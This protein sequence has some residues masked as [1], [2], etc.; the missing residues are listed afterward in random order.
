MIKLKKILQNILSESSWDVQEQFYRY[1]DHIAAAIG[2]QI[3]KKLGMGANGVAF[4]TKSGKVLKITADD[5]EIAAAATLRR[6]TVPLIHVAVPWDI[7]PLE[8]FKSDQIGTPKDFYL[9]LLPYVT[10]L[11]GA[12]KQ[13]WETV[14]G[15]F[16]NESVKLNLERL[17]ELVA[18]EKR[19]RWGSDDADF[20]TFAE[21]LS[22]YD[23]TFLKQMM[24]QRQSILKDF[25]RAR[26]KSTEAHAD[27]IGIDKYGRIVHYDY[28]MW[29]N[30]KG[31]RGKLSLR[32]IP[33][34]KVNKEITPP[35]TKFDTTGIDTP[36]VPNM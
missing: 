17:I 25:N 21:S 27:N 26:I 14:S 28:W 7:R 2:E 16:L 22:E 1:I 23:I 13:I 36:G 24:E 32:Q 29:S 10:P 6:R 35:K 3:D 19:R 30:W 8:G 5:K 4:L 31:K 34:H 9:I 20:K 33:Q 12:Q 15:V 11:S 18:K